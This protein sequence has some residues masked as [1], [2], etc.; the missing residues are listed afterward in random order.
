MGDENVGIVEDHLLRYPLMDVT[1]K[2][3]LIM[4]SIMG[5]G[6]LANDKEKIKNVLYSEY[7]L[8]KDL[9]Y[10]YE[11]I[12]DIG[13]NFVRVYIKPFYERYK[14]F[15]KLIEA[16]SLSSKLK[17][18]I[19]KLREALEELK[20]SLDES[21]KVKV[22]EYLCSES[23]LISHSKIYKENYYPHYLVVGKKFLKDL[24]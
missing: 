10:N 17:N 15:E 18:D 14:S 16:F 22:D 21:D 9:C 20:K 19:T 3:K 5:P 7:E 13:E 11:L 12:E 4:Q 1:D 23:I 6:H 2:I 8:C 24:L